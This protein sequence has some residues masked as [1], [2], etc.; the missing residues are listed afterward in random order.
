MTKIGVLSDTHGLLPEEVY[1]F[2]SKCNE[3][4]HAGDIGNYDVIKKLQQ[5]GA[6]IRAVYG[7]IDGQD[8]RNRLPEVDIFNVEKHKVVLLHIGGTPS[9]YS[10]QSIHLIKKYSP[11]ILVCGHSHILKVQFDKNHNL[12]YI[13][14][15]AAGRNGFH[16][17]ITAIRFTA[18]ENEL[19][20][21]EVL[22]IP[23]RN[24]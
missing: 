4:W 10:P 18:N 23:R 15:G 8:I 17:S 6:I 13:N 20:D 24:G 14:P 19:K 9:R 5:T 3:I 1:K 2:L 16:K 22:D 21:M 7:N 12:L 11:S